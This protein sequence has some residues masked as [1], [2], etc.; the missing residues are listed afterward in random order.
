MDSSGTS[1]SVLGRGRSRYR[2]NGAGRSLG[3]SRI[4]TPMHA[5]IM[6]P[7]DYRLSDSAVQVSRACYYCGN[8]ARRTADERPKHGA[9][10]LLLDLWVGHHV[11]RTET[12]R[13]WA[14]QQTGTQSLPPP[15]RVILPRID[16]MQGRHSKG[17]FWLAPTIPRSLLPRLGLSMDGASNDVSAIVRAL[18]T[19]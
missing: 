8:K 17:S 11:A 2:P 4:S 18:A 9:L 7:C 5:R 6:L 13:R 19:V 12:P 10:R 3:S 16:D 15:L 14:M 1:Q